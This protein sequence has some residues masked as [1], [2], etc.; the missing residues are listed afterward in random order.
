MLV[1]NWMSKNVVT[2]D[3]D[4]SMQHAVGIMRENKV[5]M[6]PVLK[7]GKL[8]GVVSD[9]DIKRASASDATA[10]DIH[11]MLYLLARI[12][13]RD[14]MTKNPVTVPPDHTV[15]E[16]AEI[17][18]Q[19]KISGVPVTDA[20]GKVLGIITR[21]DLFRVLTT[22]S[23]F[24][25]KGIQFA[26]LLEDQP[27]SIKVLTDVMRQYGARI[28]SIL[29]SY[30]QAEPGRRLVYIRI[31]NMERNRLDELR[32]ELGKKAMLIYMVDHEE[33]RREIYRDIP[34]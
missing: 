31:Y 14:I 21:D 7:K 28:A 25:K 22:L 19:K 15:E 30:E 32:G 33:N 5:R 11:E 26:F 24:G 16:T 2:I 13:I 10:L 23:G 8:V 17:L 29:T 18:S 3:E 27:G 34:A 20:D 12:K 9:T 1:K 6:L 4:D